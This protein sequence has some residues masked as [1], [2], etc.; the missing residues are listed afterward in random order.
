MSPFSFST[1]MLPCLLAAFISVSVLKSYS[2]IAPQLTVVRS[3][4]SADAA[5]PLRSSGPGS[6][7]RRFRF[8]GASPRDAGAP[9]ALRAHRANW[10]QEGLLRYQLDGTA[11][12]LLWIKEVISGVSFQ[13]KTSDKRTSLEN[14][15]YYSELKIKLDVKKHFC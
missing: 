14:Q 1:V 11:S 6:G 5:A 12:K 10:T 2:K 3:S 13:S 7:R 15:G 8:S 9:W 4:E